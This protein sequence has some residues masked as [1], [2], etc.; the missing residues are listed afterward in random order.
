MPVRV[1]GAG[2]DRGRAPRPVSRARGETW[3]SCGISLGQDSGGEV[4]TVSTFV[5][6]QERASHL[7]EPCGFGRA[8][9]KVLGAGYVSAYF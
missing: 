5:G 3:N 7:G 6:L 1:P 9:G 2:R 4:Q 8:A